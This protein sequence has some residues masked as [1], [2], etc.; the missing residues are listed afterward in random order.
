MAG[1]SEHS[2][3]VKDTCTYGQQAQA[4][5]LLQ[6]PVMNLLENNGQN[7]LLLTTP[8]HAQS[9]QNVR[10]CPHPRGGTVTK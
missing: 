4:E 1:L 6:S 3:T 2:G 9:P 7:R 8:P 10:Q 5:A